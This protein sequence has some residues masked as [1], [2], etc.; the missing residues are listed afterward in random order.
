MERIERKPAPEVTRAERTKMTILQKEINNRSDAINRMGHLM[1][2]GLVTITAD[3]ESV[4]Q[5]AMA[6]MIEENEQNRRQQGEVFKQMP[7]L[8]KK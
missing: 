1:A 8:E 4:F 3:R 2:A 6:V 7:W 5:T